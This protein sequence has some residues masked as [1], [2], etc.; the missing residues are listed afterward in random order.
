ML[1]PTM[2]PSSLP[3][4]T[5]KAG[6]RIFARWLQGS[7][8]GARDAVLIL[9]VGGGDLENNVSPNLVAAIDYAKAVGARVLGIVG[10]DGGHTARRAD[11]CVIIPTPNPN[12][13]DAACGSVSGSR[14]ASAGLTPGVETGADE[15]GVGRSELPSGLSGPRWRDKPSHRPGW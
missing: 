12:P 1:R 2:F 6:R 9:S 8:L 15:M 4:P 13:H 7:R 11:V 14:L 3:A 10:R 5:T